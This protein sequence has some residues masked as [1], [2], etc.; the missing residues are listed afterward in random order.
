M[1]DN[2]PIH[3][4]EAIE[5]FKKFIA[6]SPVCHFMT[7]LD[8]RPVPTRPMATQQVDDE[9]NFWFLSSRSSEKDT[10]IVKDSYVQLL[11]SNPSDSEFLSL[12]GTATV[13][14]DMAK[15]RE[16]F[17]PLAK[18]WFPKG[19]E[20]PDLSVVKVKP[21]K[22]YYWGSKHGKMLTLLQMA[23]SALVGKKSDS[24]VVGKISL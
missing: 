14:E 3:D 13:V 8:E 16:L 6:H 23:A 1:P 15:K 12:Y 22:G 21:L 18:A 7:T 19:P 24:G 5:K 10:D 20:D 17:G 4:T 11:Y 9:G 2:K